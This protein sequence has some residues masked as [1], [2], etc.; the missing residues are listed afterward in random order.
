MSDEA[1]TAARARL[2][3]PADKNKV[4]INMLDEAKASGNKRDV[5]LLSDTINKKKKIITI[6]GSSR[7][8]IVASRAKDLDDFLKVKGID[9][10]SL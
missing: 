4:L 6:S 5:A 2:L 3:D 10:V 8:D 1:L 9:D 7:G